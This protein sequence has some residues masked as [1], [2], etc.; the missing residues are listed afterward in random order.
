MA[1]LKPLDRAAC[2]CHSGCLLRRTATTPWP[3]PSTFRQHSPRRLWLRQC[4]F[5]ASST[6]LL[7][8]LSL[9]L[10]RLCQGVESNH[11]SSLTLYHTPEISTAL[12]RCAALLGLKVAGRRTDHLRAMPTTWKKKFWL[13][14]IRAPSRGSNHPHGL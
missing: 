10:F 14:S 5:P 12:P 7:D 8:G 11:R 4:N 6:L 13:F 3:Y 9:T 2:L 1:A